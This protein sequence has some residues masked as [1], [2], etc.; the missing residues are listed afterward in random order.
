MKDHFDVTQYLSDLTTE[1]IWK[2]GGALGLYYPK[3]KKMKNPLED[4]VEAWLNREDNV[5]N[6]SGPPHWKSLVKAL[7]EIDCTG[8]AEK[9]R[10]EKL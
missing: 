7:K 6:K 9:I 3:L 10:K 8:H 2:L 1:K 5:C 4:M